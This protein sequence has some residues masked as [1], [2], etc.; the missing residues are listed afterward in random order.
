MVTK[1]NLTVSNKIN[2]KIK[3]IQHNNGISTKDE[4]LEKIIDHIDEEV[5][6]ESGEK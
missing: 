1:L 4:V 2:D 5:L 6:F 3:R